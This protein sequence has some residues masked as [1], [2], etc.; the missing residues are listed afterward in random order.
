MKR[1]T[2]CT[3]LAAGKLSRKRPRTENI[4]AGDPKRERPSTIGVFVYGT[5]LSA[6]G[7]PADV[8]TRDLSRTSEEVLLQDVLC[9]SFVVSKSAESSR[10][11]AVFLGLRGRPC[12][13]SLG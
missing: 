13:V 4:N 2:F 6:G 5:R 7:L 3:V 8:G 10:L 12:F 9:A 11:E 1:G